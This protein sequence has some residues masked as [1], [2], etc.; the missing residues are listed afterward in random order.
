MITTLEEIAY[1]CPSDVHKDNKPRLER[2]TYLNK[3]ISPYGLCNICNVFYEITND[4]I[5]R[6]D[7]DAIDQMPYLYNREGHQIDPVDLSED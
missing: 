5:F 4:G 6:L 1:E 2:F 3:S 7:E